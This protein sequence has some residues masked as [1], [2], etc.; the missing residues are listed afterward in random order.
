MLR[1]TFVAIIHNLD[2]TLTQPME[3]VRNTFNT[4]EKANYANTT[5]ERVNRGLIDHDNP[6]TLTDS[7]MSE[8]HMLPGVHP[9]D[10]KYRKLIYTG[11]G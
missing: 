1:H 11:N 7:H 2:D 5:G 3:P 4:R 6:K 8:C 9:G 10:M